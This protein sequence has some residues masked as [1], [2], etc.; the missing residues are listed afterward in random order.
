MQQFSRSPSWGTAKLIIR[1]RFLI[2]EQ[3]ITMLKRFAVVLI[4]VVALM[5]VSV[6][7]AQDTPAVPQLN[8][9]GA[10]F[11]LTIYNAW[12]ADYA[13]EFGVQ[14]NYAGGG[15]GRGQ[16]DIIAN[17]VDFG[18]TDSFLN[19]AQLGQARCG[20]VVHVPT[21]LGGIAMIYNIPEL[22]GQAPLQLRGNEIAKIYLNEITRWNDPLLVALNPQLASIDR[23]IL[24]VFRADSSGT[25]F[26]FTVFLYSEN[27]NW[28]QFRVGQAINWLR[29]QSAQ[30]NPGVAG[31]V[32]ASPYS[33]G[34]VE[35]SF[36][37]DLDYAAI[38]NP[39]GGFILPTPE[40]IS[41]AAEGVDIPADTRIVLIYRSSN[42]EA[43]PISTF[44]WLVACQNQANAGRAREITRY[45]WWATHEGQSYAAGLDYAPLPSR[46][47]ALAEANILSINNP[48]GSQALP[49]SIASR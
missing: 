10:T 2:K 15:S 21:V 8:A 7:L 19:D 30:G 48:D 11:P 33:L 28:G 47:V 9:S 36:V 26:N 39:T 3:H 34:Y 46:V 13:E 43:Y 41:L 37:G 40:S 45:L 23:E 4:F 17:V 6:I 20:R 22:A 44:T 42:P 16:R 27:A 18:G 5:S 49:T 1:V 14:V 35:L 31:L 12:N 29:G 38:K 25:T 32:N 24:P